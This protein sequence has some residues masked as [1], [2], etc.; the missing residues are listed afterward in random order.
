MRRRVDVAVVLEL[1]LDAEEVLLGVVDE[2]EPPRRHA[3][4][5]AAQLGADRAAGAGDHDHLAAEVAAD[6]VELHA[7]GLAA[8]DVLDLHLAHL[9][10][11]LARAGLQQL[12]DRRQ[13]AHRDPALARRA[14]HA[15]AQRARRRRDGD[16]DLVGLG[17]VEDA[18][19]LVGRARGP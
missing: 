16:G 5:L 1:A 10:H 7:H 9:A 18:P 17:L 11:D 3:R 6:A 14:H 4:D 19:E 8:E 12:E 15:R 2:H 13:R